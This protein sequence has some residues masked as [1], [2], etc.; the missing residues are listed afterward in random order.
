M[1]RQK[2]RTSRLTAD[3][4]RAKTWTA[5]ETNNNGLVLDDRLEEGKNDEEERRDVQL[6]E[7]ENEEQGDE[8]EDVASDR[9]LKDCK[10]ITM[11]LAPPMEEQCSHHLG[12]F[13]LAFAT[14]GS[15]AN[16]FRSFLEMNAVKLSI[17]WSPPAPSSDENG[18]LIALGKSVQVKVGRRT[19]TEV[20]KRFMRINFTEEQSSVL[21]ALKKCSGLFVMWAAPPFSS[22]FVRFGVGLQKCA[23]GHDADA[24]FSSQSSPDS[25]N[26]IL[27]FFFPEQLHKLPKFGEQQSCRE[28]LEEL[29]EALKQHRKSVEV[30]R[31]RRDP[32]HADLV[33]ALRPYQQEAVQWM[34][35]RETNPSG[36]FGASVL[37]DKF[38]YISPPHG[39]PFHFSPVVGSFLHQSARAPV[40][41]PGM[42][43]L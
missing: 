38:V 30:P 1:V 20:D 11:N 4:Q 9:Y 23:F 14:N 36:P 7:E 2:V 37:A 6:E 3:E 15:A 18:W 8:G 24:V 19:R 12:F 10:R 27:A 42:Y 32:Q 31:S 35:E 25:I 43:Y 21:V 13:Q 22:E 29:Y 34:L 40:V 41:L 28:N 17:S 26:T 16:R 39:E 33:P 5:A